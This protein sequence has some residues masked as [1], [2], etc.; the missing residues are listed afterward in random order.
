MARESYRL[1]E[2]FRSLAAQGLFAFKYVIINAMQ[3]LVLV[4]KNINI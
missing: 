3:L 4:N 1:R 2:L